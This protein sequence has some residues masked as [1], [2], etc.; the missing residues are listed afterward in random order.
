MSGMWEEFG[1]LQSVNSRE[2]LAVFELPLYHKISLLPRLAPCR[3][4]WAVRM[5]PLSHRFVEFH[6]FSSSTVIS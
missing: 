2:T 6:E 1:G 3:Y 5:F 4:L